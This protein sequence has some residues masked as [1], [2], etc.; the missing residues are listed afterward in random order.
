MPMYSLQTDAASVSEHSGGEMSK[1]KLM[2]EALKLAKH[3]GEL[4]ER[5]STELVQHSVY[6]GSSHRWNVASRKVVWFGNI[7]P[8]H[9]LK[10]T[11]HYACN[12]KGIFKSSVF[13]SLVH[14]HGI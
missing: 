4:R 6:R 13:I 8:F 12:Y 7:F 3:K 2:K 10:A 1:G 9:G 5:E 14:G 11:C